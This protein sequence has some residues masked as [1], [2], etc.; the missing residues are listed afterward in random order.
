M[1]MEN[2]DIILKTDYYFI[3]IYFKGILHLKL[4]R[5]ELVGFQ[6]WKNEKF[7]CIEYTFTNNNTILELLDKEL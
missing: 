4:N 1:S 6:S 5:E 3:K 7:F 2:T